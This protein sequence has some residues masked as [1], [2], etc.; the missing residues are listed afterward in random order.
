MSIHRMEEA[1][2]PRKHCIHTERLLTTV[3]NVNILKVS[4]Y[5]PVTTHRG[6]NAVQIFLDVSVQKYDLDYSNTT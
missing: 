2:A 5:L 3:K 1:K 6:G 4:F